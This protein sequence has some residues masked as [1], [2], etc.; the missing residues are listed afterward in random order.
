MNRPSFFLS[1]AVSLAFSALLF[2]ALLPVTQGGVHLDVGDVAF[3][4]VRA[5]EDISFVSESLTRQRRDEAAAAVQETLVYDPAVAGAQQ[6]QLSTLLKRVDEVRRD[7][8]L[9]VG[10]R[11]A[12]LA[13]V[14]KLSL[15][16]GSA[17]L[18]VGLSQEDFASVDTEARRA[19]GAIMEQSLS[20]VAV[21]EAR[22]RASTYV[23]E[24]LDRPKATLIAEI[25]RPLIVPNLVVDRARTDAA[26]EAARAAVA[27]VQI[28]F[29]RN[30]PI[31][32]KDAPVTAEAREALI[33][34]GL[35]KE[36]WQPELVGA[37]AILA[38]LGGGGL[39]LAV[40]SFRPAILR[41]PRPALL[42]G[43]CLVLPVLVMKLY[44]PYVLPDDQRHFLAFFMPVA[45]PAL[46]LSALFGAEIAL[47][48]A[49][50]VALLSGFSAVYL[51]DLTVVGLAGALEVAQLTL[52]TGLGAAGGVLAVSNADRLSSFLRGGAL[53][54]IGVFGGL[55]ATW[56]VDPDREAVDFAWMG[57]AAAANGA[58]SGFLS[59]GAFVTVASLFGVTTRLQLLEMSQVSQPLLRRLQEEAPSTFQHS[60]IVGNL[61]E[62]AAYA[63]G[64]DSLLARVGSYY[65]DVGKMLRPGFFIENQ[66]GG[67]NPHDA[68]DPPDSAQIIAD[69]VRDGMALA[70]QYR[71]P[72]RVAAFIPEHHG[73]RLITYFY[74]RAS[75]EDPL[76]S[77]DLFRYPGP[78][79]QSRETAIV[80]LADSCEALVRAEQDHSAER[81]GVL[82]DE[83]FG[84][85]LAEGQ[86]DEC[87]LTLRD[88]RAVA[89]SFKETLRAVYHPR[90][91]YPAPTEAEMLLRRLPL[92]RPRLLDRR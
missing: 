60:I 7:E 1:L 84:E 17:N 41:R 55:A 10:G 67:D 75:E 16:A 37:S 72:E 14:D 35:I 49:G 88:L 20:N 48:V 46:L 71:L 81:I 76:V 47:A 19:L 79:P 6:A 66:L 87:N 40:R 45:A 32:E 25:I 51:S 3:R 11:V 58:L 92:P 70:R 63:I 69:H 77:P 54:G 86:L 13:R 22:E 83:V 34:G 57:A 8:S 43:L 74:R 91:E 80:M 39:A 21:T 42:V 38:V 89:A 31:V 82:V 28:T 5:P 23:D 2:L 26:R 27:P 15:S 9:S 61:A 64:A 52:A 85:R 30:Q 24:A 12:A 78:K 53:V 90:L 68:L 56:L 4:T 36:R 73:T 44:L 18:A 29:A 62:K 65:H 50:G 59:V 33:Y